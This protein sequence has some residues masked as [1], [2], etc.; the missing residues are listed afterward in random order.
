MQIRKSLLSVRLTRKNEQLQKL[1]S[2]RKA[3]NKRD[4][5]SN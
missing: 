1:L 5:S 4:L 2:L 3:S